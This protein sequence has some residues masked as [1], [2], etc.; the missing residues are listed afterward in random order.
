MHSL[1]VLNA[2]WSDFF[3]TSVFQTNTK[4]HTCLCANQSDKLWFETSVWNLLLHVFIALMLY[5]CMACWHR[6]RLDSIVLTWNEFS[7][8]VFSWNGSAFSWACGV[9]TSQGVRRRNPS[10]ASEIRE[11]YLFWAKSVKPTFLVEVREVE[12]ENTQ[13]VN[14]V[15]K[16]IL[17]QAVDGRRR[18]ASPR[19]LQQYIENTRNSSNIPKTL[20]KSTVKLHANR[21]KAVNMNSNNTLNYTNSRRT[22]RNEQQYTHTHTYFLHT[23]DS[24]SFDSTLTWPGCSTFVQSL[25]P[26]TEV[27][28][29]FRDFFRRRYCDQ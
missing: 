29:I 5:S 28:S 2:F 10:P 17:V 25:T 4:H 15:F 24:T 19:N 12:H 23:L 27:C 26:G 8:N 14:F 20:Q 16:R 21:Q 22:S 18:V 9:E 7:W 13:N 6:I 11:T 1:L 3:R